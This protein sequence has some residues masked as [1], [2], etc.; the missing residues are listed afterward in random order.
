MSPTGLSFVLSGKRPL[1][2]KKLTELCDKLEL[3]PAEARALTEARLQAP[4][5]SETSQQIEL[6]SF[7]V[8]SDWY[9]YGLLS[10]L[11]I[12][13]SPQNPREMAKALD[14]TEAEVRAAWERLKRLDLIEEKE[15]GRF[16]QKSGP[17]RIGSMNPTAASKR[18]QRQL[19]TK[20]I[21]AMENEP[22]DQKDLSSMTFALD[23]A[24]IPLARQRIR[25]FRRSLVQELESKGNA[26]RVYELT[27]QIFPVSRSLKKT[28]TELKKEKAR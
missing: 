3:D 27:V 22:D 16:K 23:P 17:I 13:N 18:F 4:V 12:E 2:K 11:E 7:S 15:G 10:L 9:H 24:L 19:L 6:D 26:S 8:I 28:K 21:E 25:D 5:T 1:S 14:I 20:A